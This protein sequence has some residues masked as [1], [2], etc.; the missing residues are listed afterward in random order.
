MENT[1]NKNEVSPISASHFY[2]RFIKDSINNDWLITRL[3]ACLIL[4]IAEQKFHAKT[5]KDPT[6]PKGQHIGKRIYYSMREVVAYS[7]RERI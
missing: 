3:G 6:F 4:G 7:E 2:R 1:I 5:Q